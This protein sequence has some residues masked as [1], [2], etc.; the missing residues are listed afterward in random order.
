MTS[1]FADD[2]DISNIRRT[3]IRR[4]RVDVAGDLRR[5]SSLH[6]SPHQKGH[7][8]VNL[9]HVFAPRF[10]PVFI[11]RVSHLLHGLGLG[12]FAKASSLLN[13]AL[14]GVE[15]AVSSDIG[16]GLYFP[17]TFGIVL[18]A[19]RIGRNATIYHGVTVGAKA[20]DVFHD[21]SSRPMVGDDVILGSG[22]KVLGPISIGDGAVV[23]ANAVTTMSVPPRTTVVGIPAKSI[24]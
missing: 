4:F 21:L 18:G 2:Q 12:V 23:G 15:I 17:H 14:F 5:Y 19:K 10:A 8:E 7:G 16:S 24:R 22:A 11:F 3:P 20:L 13:F 6:V 1:N 9:K